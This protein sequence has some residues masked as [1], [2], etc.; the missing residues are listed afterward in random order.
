MF[1]FELIK[2]CGSPDGFLDLG[3]P[4]HA[5]VVVGAPDLHRPMAL[6]PD[7]G[8][9]GEVDGVPLHFLEHTV[10]VVLLLLLK[11]LAEEAIVVKDLLVIWGRSK[12]VRLACSFLCVFDTIQKKRDLNKSKYILSFFLY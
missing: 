1:L 10:G 2:V 9:L 5:Q 11:L 7:L 3:V 4:G 6:G 8:R 12:E